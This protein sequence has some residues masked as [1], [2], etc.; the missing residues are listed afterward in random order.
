MKLEQNIEQ[1]PAESK[2]HDFLRAY[3]LQH[4]ELEGA[5]EYKAK[6]SVH[7]IGIDKREEKIATWQD[8]KPI[9]SAKEEVREKIFAEL[10]ADFAPDEQWI[11]TLYRAYEYFS[12]DGKIAE[13]Y[14]LVSEEDESR[15]R[16]M[17]MRLE[18]LHKKTDTLIHIGG[19][20]HI[21][22]GHHYQTLFTLLEKYNPI[23]IPLR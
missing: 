22:R 17:A 5:L 8:I 14:N 6:R 1:L 19:I 2:G 4:Y 9:V 7:V 23:R 15:N 3:A 20:A 16:H 13:Q 18:Q 11:E 10:C 12:D 21:L